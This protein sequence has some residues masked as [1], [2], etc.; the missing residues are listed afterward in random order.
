MGVNALVEIEEPM[1]MC[2]QRIAQ[3]VVDEVV[4]VGASETIAGFR[5]NK[6]RPFERHALF[7]ID[8]KAVYTAIPNAA[9]GDV[10][11]LTPTFAHCV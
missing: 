5:A 10:Q 7:S 2:E 3:I 8:S 1:D 11:K 4:Y 6:P 9:R